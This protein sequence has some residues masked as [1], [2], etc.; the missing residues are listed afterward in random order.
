MTVP[1]ANGSFG[2]TVET[3]KQWRCRSS[4]SNLILEEFLPVLYTFLLEELFLLYL[5]C[6]FGNAFL[7]VIDI[8]STSKFVNVQ[9]GIGHRE[10][11]NRPSETRTSFMTI[12]SEA[13]ESCHLTRY[14]R[15]NCM[16]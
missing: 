8:S 5:V 6:E 11:Q 16:I 3:V 13:D 14:P 9:C 15:M 10:Y 4:F 2:E 12:V 1:K 7:I